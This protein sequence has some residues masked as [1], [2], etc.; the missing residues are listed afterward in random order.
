MVAMFARGAQRQYRTWGAVVAMKFQGQYVSEPRAHQAS[1]IVH[2]RFLNKHL[3]HDPSNTASRPHADINTWHTTIGT[4]RKTHQPP[5]TMT[6]I[7]GTGGGDERAKRLSTGS[8]NV[9]Q[10]SPLDAAE[11][12]CS[13]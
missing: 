13:R 6:V 2:P 5:M 8:W 3:A 1:T 12:L 11:I 4:T 9:E 7:V 10:A